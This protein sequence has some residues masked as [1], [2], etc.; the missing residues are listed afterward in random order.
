MKLVVVVVALVLILSNI[1]YTE[2]AET[3]K[4]LVDESRV[5]ALLGTYSFEDTEGSSG[6]GS[7]AEK[8]RA[9]GSIDIKKSGTLTYD[10]LK[11]Y[12]VLVIASYKDKY[13]SSEADAIRKF[14]ENG[15]GLLFMSDFLSSGD[16]ANSVS[17][18]FNVSFDSP[19]LALIVDDKAKKFA[20]GSFQFYA[21]DIT[22]HPITEGVKQVALNGAVPISKYKSGNVLIKTSSNSW[23][24]ELG[25]TS[26]KKDIDEESGP[27]DILLAMENIGKGRAVFFGCASSF[28]NWVVD[29]ADQQNLKLLANAVEWLGEPGGPYK[30]YKN[31]NE[32]AQ[33]AFSDAV[34]LFDS[35]KFSE[36][37]AG[38]EGAILRFEESNSIFKNADATKG[39]EDAKAYIAKCETGMEADQTFA[40]A[41]SL[42]DSRDYEKAIEEFNNA[43]P[44]YDEIGYTE[45]SNECTAKVDECNKWIALRD[46][47]K[48][49]FQAA[50]DAFSKAPSTFSTA[51]YTQAKSLYEEAR[52][53]WKEYNDP[54]QVTAC[55]EKI[56]QCDAEIAKINRNLMMVTVAIV[57][58]VVVIVIVVVFLRMRK[59]K[60]EAPPPAAP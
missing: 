52:K 25:K 35:H 36:A 51:G 57:V 12:D 5:L 42:L 26:N 13:S 30:Q 47:A 21:T 29:T 11:N 16:N 59:P 46:K 38:F 60:A 17:K 15:G 44:L 6:F 3:I 18:S 56:S 7:A 53:T 4:V 32:K 54:A 1:H 2:G 31:L 55:D 10:E 20:S 27:F 50:E 24:D 9:V 58:I 49:Q 34:A 37:K 33:Q 40:K 19:F 43:K 45:K 14:V 8:I 23:V 39:I 41:L 22:S 28:F 48:Q